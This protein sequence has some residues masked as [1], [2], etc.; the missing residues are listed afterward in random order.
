MPV[1]PPSGH[2]SVLYGTA[3]QVTRRLLLLVS[4]SGSSYNEVQSEVS[5]STP[6]LDYRSKCAGVIFHSLK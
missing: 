3:M 2:P 6:Q 5:Y 1:R 4:G